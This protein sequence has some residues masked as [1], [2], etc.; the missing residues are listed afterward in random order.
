MK[1]TKVFSEKELNELATNLFSDGYRYLDIYK[2][3]NERSTDSK[4]ISRI[5]DSMKSN[6]KAKAKRIEEIKEKNKQFNI[7]TGT[8][9]FF[10]LLMGIVIIVSG[11]LF[12]VLLFNSGFI[13][14]FSIILF[15]G[16]FVLI[17]RGISNLNK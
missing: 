4:L 13:S 9:P 15:I 7:L 5:I 10:D 8:N 3:L 11:I 12:S 1:Q 6:E 14:V 16:G 17:I 2:Y